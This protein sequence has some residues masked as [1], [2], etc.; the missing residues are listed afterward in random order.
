MIKSPNLEYIE[1]IEYYVLQNKVVWYQMDT[2]FKKIKQIDIPTKY[3]PMT[4]DFYS[5]DENVIIIDSPLLIDWNHLCDSE[6][7]IHFNKNLPTY[8]YLVNKQTKKI[9]QY[10]FKD[11]FYLFHYGS[12][13]ITDKSITILA[14]FYDNMNYNTIYHSGKYRKLYIDRKIGV[15][16]FIKLKIV[17]NLNLDFPV[18][19]SKN[20]IVLRAIHNN[21]IIGFYIFNDLQIIKKLIWTDRFICGEPAVSYLE[22]G[23]PILMCLAFSENTKQQFF[24]TIHLETYEIIE[25]LISYPLFV[26]FH[27]TFIEDLK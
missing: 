12:V 9:K 5:D 10:I 2:H 20:R 8:I 19:L 18:K 24:M 16:H 23:D 7:P 3:L 22:N 15:S 6:V 14:P 17:E 26:G 4:H 13:K 1:T 21:C 11:S 27:A 25:Y